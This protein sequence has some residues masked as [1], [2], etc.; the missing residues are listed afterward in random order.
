MKKTISLVLQ[1]LGVIFIAL[2]CVVSYIFLSMPWTNENIKSPRQVKGEL[3]R[4]GINIDQTIDILYGSARYHP[5]MDDYQKSWCVQ[6]EKFDVT[7]IFEEQW[8]SGKLAHSVVQHILKTDFSDAAVEC[9]EKDY[10]EILELPI[11]LL[12]ANVG[13]S[14][15]S[16]SNYELYGFEALIYDSHT[17]RVSFYGHQI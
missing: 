4:S 8:Q 5:Y 6:L 10:H 3:A 16:D 11:F 1:V 7:D 9:F 12:S 13:R 15:H 14:Y 17:N 2:V